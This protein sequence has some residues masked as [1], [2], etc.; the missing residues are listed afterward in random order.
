MI[1]EDEQSALQ[2]L[3]T[4]EQAEE[5]IRD[6]DGLERTVP[7]DAEME[8]MDRW[9]IALSFGVDDVDHIIA[10]LEELVDGGG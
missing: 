4:E 2:R 1:P 5:M 9:E 7:E 8:D 10:E 3:V 6:L